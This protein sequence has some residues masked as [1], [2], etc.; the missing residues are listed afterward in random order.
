MHKLSRIL[1]AIGDLALL[2]WIASAGALSPIQLQNPIP[3]VIHTF[4][5]F[6][7]IWIIVGI[8]TDA[9]VTENHIRRFLSR[10]VVTWLIAGSIAIILNR[11]IQNQGLHVSGIFYQL[12]DSLIL[13]LLWRVGYRMLLA[14]LQQQGWVR[15]FTIAGLI[16]VIGLS[17]AVLSLKLSIV[18]RFQDDIHSV[19]TVPPMQTALVFGAGLW[20][21]G[22]S[23]TVMMNR[24]NTAVSLYHRGAVQKIIMSGDGRNPQFDESAVMQQLAIDAGVPAEDIVLDRAGT[25]TYNS[26][27][28]I[29]NTVAVDSAILVTHAYHLYRALYTCNAHGLDV[30]GVAPV[31][32]PTAFKSLVRR[33]VRELAATT[34]AW[35]DLFIVPPI[36]PIATNSQS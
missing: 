6:A 21:D 18:L 34:L 9:F 7:I 19:Q 2:L 14:L 27:H 24:V 16:L 25:R 20:Y 5:L 26:C 32:N 23:S 15:W 13:L 8:Y 1:L 10:T 17:A 33:E 31:E 28:Y 36:V 30:V 35:W 4:L 22:T 11:L 29:A 12:T 3:I